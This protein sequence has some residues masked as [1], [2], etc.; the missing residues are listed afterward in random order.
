MSERERTTRVV[1]RAGIDEIPRV[2]AVMEEAMR[3]CTFPDD[4]ILDLQLAVEEA[5]T[6]II[7]HGY[8]GASG[9]VEIEIQVT[10]KIAKVRIMDQAP[11]FDPLSVPDPD[12]I[13][14]LSERR[15][16][17]LGIYLMR[18]VA[19]EVSYQ[20]TEGRNIL[21]IMKKKTN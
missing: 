17:G 15:T 5:I 12:R 20:F 2:S 6:N 16:G 14:E 8:Q 4:A 9:E 18:Q 11:P 3:E 1:I 19:D 13:S 10:E 21:T 7:L